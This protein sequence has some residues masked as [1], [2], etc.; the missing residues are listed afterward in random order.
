MI[1]SEPVIIPITPHTLIN[2]CAEAGG[3]LFCKH[4]CPRLH[5]SENTTELTQHL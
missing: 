1:Q 3:P 5:Q 4:V 2:Q